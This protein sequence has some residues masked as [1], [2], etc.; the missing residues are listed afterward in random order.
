MPG[1][2]FVV[3]EGV[4]TARFFPVHFRPCSCSTVSM[5]KESVHVLFVRA[6]AHVQF[7]ASAGEPLASMRIFY[8]SSCGLFFEQSA[9]RK[10]FEA[11]FHTM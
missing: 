8:A 6:C 7:P 3:R 9:I 4:C 11:L 2:F 10:L 1:V 5:N